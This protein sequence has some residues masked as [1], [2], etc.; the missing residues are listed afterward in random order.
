MIRFST[1]IEWFVANETRHTL[2]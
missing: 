2:K 1:K